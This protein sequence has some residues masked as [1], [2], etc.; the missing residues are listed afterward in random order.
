MSLYDAV[1]RGDYDDEYEKFIIKNGDKR[2][3]LMNDVVDAMM[4]EYLIE[5]F[6]EH[7]KGNN[8]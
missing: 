7:L 6:M 4:N 8:V 5:D 3:Y 1:L 2:I